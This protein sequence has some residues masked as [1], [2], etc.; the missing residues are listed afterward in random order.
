MPIDIGLWEYSIHPTIA[1][2]DN[3]YIIV[4]YIF[5]LFIFSRFVHSIS[6]VAVLM[7]TGVGMIM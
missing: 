7:E 2:L 3:I 4:M 5:T 1:I 6:V